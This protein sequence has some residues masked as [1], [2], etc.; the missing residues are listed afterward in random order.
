MGQKGSYADYGPGWA[1]TA[2]TPNSYYKTVS[3]EGALRVPFIA[4]Y[5]G[6][7]KAN[8]KT[9]TFAFVKD[10]YPTILEIT[11][12]EKPTTTYSGKK[13]HEPDGVSAWSV[14]IGKAEAVHF[15]SETI[16]YELMGGS[17]VFQG[18]YKLSINPPP[19]GTC[20]WDLYD[21]STDPYK[22]HDLA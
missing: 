21:I 20:A 3:T 5:P 19:K 12:V 18:K 17:T 6:K 8:S 15:G 7:I 10:T 14:F 9:N 13:I 16:G 2:N 1:A 11:G 4:N 22:L